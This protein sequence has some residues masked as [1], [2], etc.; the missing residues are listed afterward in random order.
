MCFFTKR[1]TSPHPCSWTTEPLEDAP[2]TSNPDTITCYKSTRLP[3]ECSKQVFCTAK[4]SQLL[5]NWGCNNHLILN[6][7]DNLRLVN[8]IQ[9][10]FLKLSRATPSFVVPAK[11][12]SLVTAF[13]YPHQL[14]HVC[15]S[16]SQQR[17]YCPLLPPLKL[18]HVSLPLFQCQ[19]AA[20][21]WGMT[22]WICSIHLT[23]AWW[24]R[25]MICW[26]APVPLSPSFIVFLPLPLLSHSVSLPLL[27]LPLFRCIS[28]RLL[29]LQMPI[30]LWDQLSFSPVPT[31]APFLPLSLSLSLSLICSLCK[32]LQVALAG[33]V[34]NQGKL[35]KSSL[36]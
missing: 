31:P 2:F 36:Q 17:Q 22:I 29:S 33:W 10:L 3:V 14:C 32:G 8:S 34:S 21:L 6:L 20:G 19:F 27:R 35:G 18:A 28:G 11:N 7:K 26:S 23:P 12:H 1:W 9:R 16:L 15:Q 30:F 13:S 5:W 4:T 24:S 25:G